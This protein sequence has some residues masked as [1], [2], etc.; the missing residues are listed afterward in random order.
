MHRLRPG[1]P[2]QKLLPGVYLAVTGAVTTDQREMA[3]LLH[4]GPRGVITSAVAV[5]RNGIRAPGSNVVDVLVPDQVRCQG[6]GFV[7]VHR[8]KRMP[9][10]ISTTGPI[11]FTGAARAV[12]DAA[13][14][15][16]TLRDVRGLVSDAVQRGL[17]TIAALNVE[18]EEGPKKGSALLRTALTEVSDGIR[19]VAEAEFRVLLK[20]ARLP[21]PIF[22][23]RLFDG[24]T[25]IAVVDCW[26][27]D[28]G[29]AA[30]VD[31]REYHFFAADW[32]R[33]TIRHDQLTARG[34]LVLHFSPQRIRN[35]PQGVV[36][37]LRSAL[38][39]GR[40][41]PPLAIRDV[42]PGEKAALCGK[43]YASAAGSAQASYS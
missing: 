34:V 24:D 6:L 19:S 40:G 30:E 43:T 42:P 18:L 37:E 17:C 8:T 39:A 28:A 20:R 35:D 21:M 14:T 22:N 10:R 3:A 25:L 32:Q 4:T 33:T 27:P 5:R 41:R 2:W 29:V 1:G 31:S 15:L 9:S 11:R 16:A 38:E 12:A 23:A 13:R 7:R 36:T 26:W